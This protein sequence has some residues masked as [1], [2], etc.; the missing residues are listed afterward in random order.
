MGLPGRGPQEAAGRLGAGRRRAGGIAV[1]PE[2]AKCVIDGN[3]IVFKPRDQT[4]PLLDLETIR[5]KFTFESDDG[6]KRD[7]GLAVGHQ[8]HGDE[9]RD[10]TNG[11][12]LRGDG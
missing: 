6:G 12:F 11:S 7:Q 2:Y 5:G 4:D 10:R 3:K 9:D 8:G 1:P